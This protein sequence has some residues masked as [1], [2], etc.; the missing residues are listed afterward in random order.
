MAKEDIEKIVKT[1]FST[2]KPDDAPKIS[3]TITITKVGGET[4]HNFLWD[5]T[6]KAIDKFEFD[7]SAAMIKTKG[8]IEVNEFDSHHKLAKQCFSILNSDANELTEALGYYSL[9]YLPTHLMELRRPDMIKN[10]TPMEKSAIGKSVFDLLADGNVLKTH[11]KTP[12]DDGLF[13]EEFGWFEFGDEAS[14]GPFWDW[15][16]DDDAIKY[17]GKKDREW[18]L[19]LKSESCFKQRQN[20]LEP[21]TLM[22]ADQWLRH[23]EWD[24]F[25]AFKWVHNFLELVCL[26]RTIYCYH[27]TF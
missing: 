21:L 12:Q 10:M 5:L 24:A 20:L 2:R 22:V 14:L 16:T 3:A 15:L 7:N 9:C 6:R 26:P 4:V 8:T 27:A 23:R 13:F 11:W 18:L 1:P 17:L 19:K 25:P